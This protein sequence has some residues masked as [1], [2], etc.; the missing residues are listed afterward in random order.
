MKFN[1]DHVYRKYIYCETVKDIF[2]ADVYYHHK[3][4]VNYLLMYERQVNLLLLNFR[5]EDEGDAQEGLD[6]ISNNLNFNARAY[7]LTE[8][9]KY[10]G[11]S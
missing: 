10:W 2:A 3:C 7:K 9:T 4:M 5:R 1:D 11:H 8:I 6:Q